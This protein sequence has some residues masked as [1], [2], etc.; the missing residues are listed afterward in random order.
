MRIALVAGETSGDILGADLLKSLKQRFPKV[1]FLGI[2]G[3]LMQAEGMQSM[4]EMDKLSIMGLEGLRKSLR[5][6]LSIR[7]QLISYLIDN[8]PDLFIGIDAPDFNLTVEERL[9]KAGIPVVH[10]VSPTVWAW[11]KYRIRKIR[12]AV[13]LMLTLFPFE[14]TFYQQHDVPVE[15]VGH[16]LTAEIQPKKVDIMYRG[17]YASDKQMLIAVL[18]GS[19][20]S[21]IRALGP[22][23]IDVMREL[24]KDGD[25]VQFIIPTVTSKLRRL[26]KG[27]LDTNDGNF[28]H[29]VDGSESRRA[30]SASD[31]VLLASGTAA[32]EAALL[33]KPMVVA[34]KLS[35]LTYF[36][37]KATTTV[38]HAS[39]PNHLLE[40]PIVPEYI[41]LAA[42]KNNLITEIRRYMQ[43]DELREQTSQK[44]AEI[45]PQLAY[46]SSELAVDAIEELLSKKQ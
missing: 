32:L 28:I 37:A 43:D 25:G 39:M 3:P 31:M 19:R 27:F 26:F 24:N 42:S 29:L 38:K 46:D 40:K 2:A 6:I 33:A 34:Y 8:P 16:P 13:D 1:E 36:F 45:H 14:K 17:N 5:E 10:Y 18:P 44:L 9:R 30:M 35:W 23:F 12:R 15:F 4:A 20:T 22:L 41:Q 7:R 21:E 11:R